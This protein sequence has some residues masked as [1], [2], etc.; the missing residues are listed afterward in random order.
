V[1]I[2]PKKKHRISR[3]QSIELSKVNR[4]R[5]TSEDIS[6]PLGREK[7][8]II[9]GGREGGSWMGKGTER[10]EGNMIRY[11]VREKD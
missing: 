1:G 5:D 10:E 2:S 11:W 7:K 6:I 4:L 9:G 3:I 8:A